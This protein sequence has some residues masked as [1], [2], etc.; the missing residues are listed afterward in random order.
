MKRRKL[1]DLGW[2]HSLY[3]TLLL[4]CMKD[5]FWVQ[6]Y[7]PKDKQTNPPIAIAVPVE[8]VAK[9]LAVL[10]NE[11]FGNKV[12]VFTHH[13]IR[14]LSVNVVHGLRHRRWSSPLPRWCHFKARI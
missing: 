10:C 8:R 4:M 3:G 7:L 2:H 5:L 11:L 12:K 6:H 1:D 9:P 14:G 13:S